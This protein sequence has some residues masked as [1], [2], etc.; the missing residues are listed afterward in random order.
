MIAQ[1]ELHEGWK[2]KTVFRFLR[3]PISKEKQVTF[4]KSSNNDIET[5]KKTIEALLK[6]VEVALTTVEELTILLEKSKIKFVDIEF[7]P[8]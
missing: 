7:P 4:I 1:V 6:K 2:L 8:D 3:K 5:E